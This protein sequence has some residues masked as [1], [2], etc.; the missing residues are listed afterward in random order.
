M[1]VVLVVV[2]VKVSVILMI[3]PYNL[4]RTHRKY[5]YKGVYIPLMECGHEINQR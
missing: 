3:G 2:V 4:N 5:M 1:L